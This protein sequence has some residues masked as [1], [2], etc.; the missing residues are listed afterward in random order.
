ML[1]EGL[2]IDGAGALVGAFTVVV[3]VGATVVGVTT[4]VGVGTVV[5]GLVEPFESER[6][7]WVVDEAT[8]RE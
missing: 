5:V 2:E 4:V 3:V 1:A 7:L 8:T 6:D